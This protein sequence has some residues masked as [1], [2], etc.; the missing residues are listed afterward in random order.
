MAKFSSK[1]KI[2]GMDYSILSKG[3]NGVVVVINNQ[4]VG[5][6]FELGASK[7][8]AAAMKAAN[9]INSLV[10]KLL[11]VDIT[12][13]YSNE[14]LVMERLYPLQYRALSVP[15]REQMFDSFLTQLK[16]LHSNGWAH[17]DIKRPQ[18]VDSHW[19]NIVLIKSGIRLIDTGTAVSSE[20]YNFKDWC[21]RDISNAMEFKEVFLKP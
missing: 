18:W 1:I 17:G 5:K 3:E 16:E 11:R 20:H 13:G 12:M 4:E 2:D 10:V 21:E 6:I 7:Q 9:K 19:D 15:E 14:L 8:E